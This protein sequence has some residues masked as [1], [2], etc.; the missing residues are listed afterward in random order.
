MLNKNKSL[1]IAT[2]GT[3]VTHPTHLY[4]HQLEMLEALQNGARYIVSNPRCG[5]TRPCI[6]FLRPHKNVLVLTKKQAIAGWHSELKALGVEGWTVLNY[7][8][9][10]TKGW[11]HSIE[12]GA[13]VLD[14][15]HSIGKY[16]KPN[17]CVKAIYAMKVLGPRIGI[18]ATP[19]AE[20]YSQLFHQAKA[21]KMPLWSDFKNFYLWHRAYGI[22]D[23][24]R[25]NGRMLETYKKVKEAAWGEF[26][27]FCCV[28]DRQK[29]MTDF[30]EAVDN[31]VPI[32][33]PAVLQMCKELKRDGI[34]HVNGGRVIVAETPLALAQKCAQICSGVVLDD[35]GAAVTVNHAKVKW[36][37]RFKGAKIAV[38][39]TFKAEVALITKM[40]GSVGITDDFKEFSDPSFTGWFVGSIQRFNAGVDLSAASALVFSSCP[41]SAVQYLQARDR[42]LRRDRARVAPV[43]FPVV[44]GGIDEMIFKVVA[45]SKKDFTARQ[46]L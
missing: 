31:V 41:W 22:P 37:E 15:A 7:E 42:L 40:W 8:K 5:K 14:E 24:I 34:I 45:G 2:I 36:L 38:L 1:N 27:A 12:W 23:Q 9:V 11:D 16:P 28:V 26:K 19:C 13:L 46:Y 6:E 32:E 3:R 29:V 44:A 10:R 30:V 35:E 33:A 39:T 4:P 25:A 17:L 20:S 21:L 18:S 43:Y